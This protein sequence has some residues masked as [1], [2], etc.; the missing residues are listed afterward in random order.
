MPFWKSQKSADVKA[1][2]EKYR[3]MSDATQEMNG[4]TSRI[5]ISNGKVDEL[6]KQLAASL[7]SGDIS[8][9]RSIARQIEH[10]QG[11]VCT[12]RH[13]L[14]CI[15]AG[16]STLEGQ[17]SKSIVN[18]LEK[19]ARGIEMKEYTGVDM[20]DRLREVNELNHLRERQSIISELVEEG[21][22]DGAVTDEH[23]SLSARA[24]EILAM[25]QGRL[26]LQTQ[27]RM[28]PMP[29]SGA[30]V[31][32]NTTQQAMV[33]DDEKRTDDMLMQRLDKLRR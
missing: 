16:V 14:F 23:D 10:T 13:N 11:I 3:L 17:T 2:V 26:A 24:T 9:A 25:A 31:A 8:G 27:D 1:R 29:P 7:I 18:K 28:Q 33:V 19:A 21:N 30:P 4:L 6:D 22:D 15:E 5:S 20:D 32:S 12:S